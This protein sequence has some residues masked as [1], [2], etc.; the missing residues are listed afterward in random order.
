MLMVDLRFGPQ[1][2]QSLDQQSLVM[3][4]PNWQAPHAQ[5]QGLPVYLLSAPPSM[6]N[7]LFP[8]TAQMSDLLFDTASA[9][10]L[11]PTAY[12]WTRNIPESGC[13]NAQNEAF[14]VAPAQPCHHAPNY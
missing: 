9:G 2:V 3:A 13:Y 12:L 4:I 5:P 6:S 7:A 11:V 14:S 1:K 10:E 8:P